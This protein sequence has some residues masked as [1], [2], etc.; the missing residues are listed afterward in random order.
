MDLFA[1]SQA[2][3][4]ALPFGLIGVD[5]DGRIEQ[6]NAFE[7]NLSRLPKERVIG[8]NFFTDVAPCTA[9]K[10]FQGRFEAFVASGAEK[11]ESFDFIFRFSF[12]QQ[13]VSITFVRS[14]KSR[15]VMIVANRADVE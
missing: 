12:G 8:R 14:T 4:D 7:S 2:Q 15:R 6:Y 11:A 3:I 5:A 9:V 10:D 1:L 13:R